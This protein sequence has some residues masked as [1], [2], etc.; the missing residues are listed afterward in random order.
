LS[1]TSSPTHLRVLFIAAE[2][3]PLIKVGGLG[4]VA[5]SLPLAIRQINPEIDI[6]LAIPYYGGLKLTAP[7]KRVTSY[8]IPSK[9][10][11]VKADVFET[12]SSGIS[13]YLIAGEPIHKDA[14]VYGTDFVQDAEKFIFFSLACLF[15]PENIGWDID[16]LHANDWHTAVTVHQLVAL[17]KVDK[18]YSQIKTVLTV[19][20]LP[21]MGSGSG[22]AIN[23]FG[24][25]PSENPSM[26]EW[27]R[28]LPLP[29]GLNAA[30]QIVAVSPSYVNEILTSAYGCDLQDFLATRKKHISGILNGIDTSIWNPATDSLIAS[31]FTPLTL[32]ERSKNKLALQKELGFPEDTA[33]PLLASIG[34][35]DTQKGIDILIDSIKDL[36]GLDWQL[37]ILGSGME[38]WKQKLLTLQKS[39]PNNIR[40]EN[41]FDA[42]LSHR[43][44]A[45]AD[46]LLMPSRYEPCGLAQMIAMHY[47][48]IPIA[49][50]TG[51]LKDTI[52]DFEKQP[53]KATGFL[54]KNSDADSFVEKI[55]TA[56]SVFKDNARWQKLQKRA[57][58]CDF[59]W[60]KSAARYSSLYEEL[61]N[62]L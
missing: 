48:C 24:I 20:N 42:A 33:V 6:R 39:F 17:A 16:I 61:S 49:T 47:G 23:K 53:A 36:K 25:E 54:S 7:A 32:S 59:S 8:S 2:A 13:V 14:P 9:A 1:N 3:D 41:K 50:G 11:P 55:N 4:D 30:D 29:M 58:K 22:L 15:L 44:Y 57:M 46:M 35:L 34:R 52:I 28:Q 27:S 56:I 62:N 38:E 26:P 12:T 21:F 5:G 45:S 10:G 31:Q 43:I 60:A 37:V 51:G 18:R 19:H 40:F